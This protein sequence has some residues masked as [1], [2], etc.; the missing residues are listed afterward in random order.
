MADLNDDLSAINAMITKLQDA[1]KSKNQVENNSNVAQTSQ[2][3]LKDKIDG[4]SS[5]RKVSVLDD[6]PSHALVQWT[7]DKK[8]SFVK[9][10]SLVIM[11]G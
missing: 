7:V 2:S 8:F 10:K 6:G 1:L 4:Q 3:K 9:V 11:F 5:K